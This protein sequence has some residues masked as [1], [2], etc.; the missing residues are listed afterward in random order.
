MSGVNT[1]LIVDDGP[2]DRR[3]LE[4]ALR[5][6]APGYP[7]Y[8]TQNGEQ[9]LSYLE[10]RADKTALIFL[11]LNMPGIDGREVLRS[12]KENKKTAHIPVIV[13]TTS[14]D[15]QDVTYCYRH[16]ANSVLTKP[17]FLDDLSATIET[18]ISYWL[19]TVKIPT[20]VKMENE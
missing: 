13:L 16:Y 11:D 3:L 1:I 5:E 20:F 6:H 2:G 15:P 7:V 12:L 19:H 18:V 4:E 10:S 8:S 14:E 17:M 9:A